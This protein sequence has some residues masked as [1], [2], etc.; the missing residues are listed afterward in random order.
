MCFQNR[1]NCIQLL[2]TPFTSSQLL[3]DLSKSF[4]FPLL[5][6][7]PVPFRHFQILRIPSNIFQH[8]PI[9]S[10]FFQLLR[11]PPTSVLSLLVHS[12]PLWG[13]GCLEFLFLGGFEV[14]GILIFRLFC[15]LRVW[16]S[17]FWFLGALRFWVSWFVDLGFPYTCGTN[18]HPCDALCTT[19]DIKRCLR[20]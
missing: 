6:T 18:M 14:L 9:P 17:R 1:S 2:P 11:A 10:G 12:N 4:H 8:L 19:S 20:L 16:V 7:V 15:A 3:R 5:P 13:F